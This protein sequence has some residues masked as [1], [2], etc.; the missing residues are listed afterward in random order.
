MKKAIESG[1]P[2]S[3]DEVSRITTAY[4]NKAL[5]YRG[6]AIARTETIQSLNR[7]EFMAYQQAIADG[8]I[9]RNMVTKEWDDAGDR[10]VRPTH[11]ALAAKY[12]KGKGIPLEEAFQSPSGAQMM[13]PGDTSLGAEANEIVHCRC[14]LKIHVNFRERGEE[15]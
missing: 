1:K 11:R 3:S 8:S 4:K 15:A 2:L 5:K 13:Y 6:D 10:R 14:R 9:T 12:D 7:G